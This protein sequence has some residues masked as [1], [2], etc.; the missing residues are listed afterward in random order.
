[1]LLLLSSE[2]P[3]C[4]KTLTP[5]ERRGLGEVGCSLLFYWT[6]FKTQ[7]TQSVDCTSCF[8]RF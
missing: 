5:T 6:D 2:E 8:V 7:N 4:S 1:M 3:C